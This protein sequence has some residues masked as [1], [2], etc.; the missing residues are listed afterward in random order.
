MAT[1][2]RIDMHC[3]ILTDSGRDGELAAAG[4]ILRRTWDETG[5]LDEFPGLHAYLD[6]YDS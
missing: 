6:R 5:L 2:E 1:L 3:D 4:Q